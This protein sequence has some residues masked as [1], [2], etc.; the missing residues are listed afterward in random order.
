MEDSEG[1]L[2]AITD[3][4]QQK[5]ARQIKIIDLYKIGDS[6]C[7]WFVI[8]SAS[9]STNVSAIVNSIVEQTQNNFGIKPIATC[10]ERN[11]EW[12]AMDYGEIIVHIFIPALRSFY[13]IEHLWADAEISDITDL[14]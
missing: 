4:M 11:A 1:L 2:Q 13:D 5:K 9:S 3:G 12:V 10:G 14:D 6:L 8:C 7:R